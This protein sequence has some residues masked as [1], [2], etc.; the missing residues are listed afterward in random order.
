MHILLNLSRGEGN[1][2]MKPGQLIEYNKINVFLQKLCREWDRKTSSRPF[3]AFFKK[4]NIRSKASGLLLSFNIFRYPSTRHTIKQT[5]WNFWLLIHRDMLNFD[6]EKCLGLVSPP[7]FVYDFSRK[8]FLMSYL[9]N[10]P[11]FIVWLPLLLET[12]VNIYITIAC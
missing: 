7:L 12:L 9:I 1:Q 3:F 2:T 10:W 8:M 5:A 6:F 4:L 11:N